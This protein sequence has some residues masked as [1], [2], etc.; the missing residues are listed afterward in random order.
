MG[1]TKV[2]I[3]AMM[4]DWQKMSLQEGRNFV[5]AATVLGCCFVVWTEDVQIDGPPQKVPSW[6]KMMTMLMPNQLLASKNKAKE[7]EDQKKKP[8]IRLCVF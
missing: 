8:S 6:R 7:K 2:Q 3:M 1:T 4:P 5:K